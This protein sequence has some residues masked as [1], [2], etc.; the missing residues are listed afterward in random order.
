MGNMY[1]FAEDTADVHAY[2]AQLAEELALM[3]AEYG[4]LLY[5]GEVGT[6]VSVCG[7]GP[8]AV[9]AA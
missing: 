7:G 4:A 8:T 9:Q 2:R 3:R 6:V 5:G 1:A